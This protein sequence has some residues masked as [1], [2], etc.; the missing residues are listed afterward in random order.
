MTPSK[1][2]S[3][4]FVSVL[5]SF[6]IAQAQADQSIKVMKSDGTV[7]SY[8]LLPMHHDLD[9]AADVQA[10]LMSEAQRGS[11]VP[12]QYE[13]PHAMLPAIRDQGSRGTCAYF[14]TVGLLETY[15]MNHSSS[16][17]KTRLSEECLVDVRNW[18]ADNST[19]YTGD[20]KPDQR[21]DPNGDL[22]QSIVKTIA[23]YGVP[24]AQTYGSN[25]SCVYNGDNQYGNDVSVSDYSS[26]FSQ[27]A[28][29][30][31]GK[32][33]G[34]DVNMSPTI[35]TVKALIANNIPVEVGV[36][37]YNEYM[38]SSDWRFD[39]KLDNDSNLAGGHAILLTGYTVSNGK[40][41]FTFKN[42]W[43]D[44]WGNAGFGTM[45]DALVANSWGYDPSFDMAVSVK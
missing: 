27:G 42:S 40:T 26:I 3:L 11:R 9:H 4:L 33:L 7:G 12:S 28:S 1:K 13:I 17:G 34:F 29:F 8:R 38:D 20:D 5:S 18:M 25:L 45:D 23:Y 2:V 43:G 37:V 22:P 39:P 14:A 35:E 16:F 31:F 41:I 24:V 19:T 15:Y 30:A 36:T 21:P 6:S 32:G 10:R 44:S